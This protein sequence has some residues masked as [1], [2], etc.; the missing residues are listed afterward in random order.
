ML[1]MNTSDSNSAY[2][3]MAFF[4]A[5]ERQGGGIIA[6]C[7]HAERSNNSLATLFGLERVHILPYDRTV[8]SYFEKATGVSFVDQGIAV[9][10]SLRTT[11]IFSAI[12]RVVLLPI[13]RPHNARGVGVDLENAGPA[14]LHESTLVVEQ[15]DMSVRQYL[16][17]M[18]P[19]PAAPKCPNDRVALKI[20]HNQHIQ[21]SQ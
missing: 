19:A 2:R 18:L 11:P 17:I 5:Q 12:K 15:E 14:A 8:R 4:T 21:A 20:H 6:G 13:V 3:R 7:G 1:A 10:Q 9:W 16:G